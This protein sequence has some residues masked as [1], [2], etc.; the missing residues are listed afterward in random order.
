MSSEFGEFEKDISKNRLEDL[1]NTGRNAP[2]AALQTF[3]QTV[4]M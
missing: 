3:M 4:V 1:E 2:H